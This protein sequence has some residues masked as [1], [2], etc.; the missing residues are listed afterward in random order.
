MKKLNYLLLSSILLLFFLN[1]AMA[2]V[3]P[4][5]EQSDSDNPFNDFNSTIRFAI[6]PAFGNLTG[7]NRLEA[8]VCYW[9][10]EYQYEIQFLHLDASNQYVQDTGISFPAVSFEPSSFIKPTL[11]DWDGLN[12]LDLFLCV[13]NSTDDGKIYYFENDGNSTFTQNDNDNPFRNIS[14]LGVCKVTFGNMDDDDLPEAL[15]GTDKLDNEFRY[16]DYNGTVYEENTT[17]NPISDWN[18]AEPEPKPQL[19]NYDDDGKIDLIVGTNGGKV[20]LYLNQ[21][22]TN[23]P[24]FSTFSNLKVKMGDGSTQD[25]TVGVGS[26]GFNRMADPMIVDIDGGTNY[27]DLF[28]GSDTNDPYSGGSIGLR[29]FQEIGTTPGDYDNDTDVDLA[30]AILALKIVAGISDGT[31]IALDNRI[32][33]ESIGL[34][35]AIFALREVAFP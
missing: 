20:R 13:Q 2:Q 4:Y 11:Y 22:T 29:Y 27:V 19:L 17:N 21:S 10:S 3:N 31:T 9:N 24:D 23:F 34:E 32:S 15:V 18:S 12:G 6:S 16:F 35:E 26:A 33:G 30:D 14:D 1:S 7:D 8:V 25:I 28:I 5:Q